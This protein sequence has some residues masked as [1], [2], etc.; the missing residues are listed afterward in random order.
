MKRRALRFFIALV[1]LLPISVAFMQDESGISLNIIGIDSTNL[2]Q[3]AIHTSI[4]DSS[5]RLV[6]GLE[7]ANFSIGGDLASLANV[8][9]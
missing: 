7:V 9:R 5:E 1:L 8:T 6:S 3:I 4:L 2:S